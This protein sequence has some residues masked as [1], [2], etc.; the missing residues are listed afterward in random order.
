MQNI[1]LSP[2][3]IQENRVGSTSFT[4]GNIKKPEVYTGI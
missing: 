1:D 2:P 3:E 4:V